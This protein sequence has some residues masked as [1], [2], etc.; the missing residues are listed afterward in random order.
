MSEIKL[1]P[2]PFCGGEANVCNNIEA[3]KKI[4]NGNTRYAVRCTLGCY[5]MTNKYKTEK[6][7]IEAWN[8]RKPMDDIVKQLIKEFKKYYGNNWDEAPYLVKAI[9][10][11]RSGGKE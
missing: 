5:A 10:I 11:V 8:T 7:A 9:D 1:L 4:I 6:E 3:N 2:C